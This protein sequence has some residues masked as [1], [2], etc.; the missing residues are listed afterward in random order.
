MPIAPLS[1]RPI[2]NEVGLAVADGRVSVT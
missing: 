2:R 1:R